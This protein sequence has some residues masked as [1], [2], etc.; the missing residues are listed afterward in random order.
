MPLEVSMPKSSGEQTSYS[1]FCTEPLL[2]SAQQSVK[3]CILRD[4]LETRILVLRSP[5]RR[6]LHQNGQ[7][8]GFAVEMTLGGTYGGSLAEDLL[9]VPLSL[10][11]R[12][13]RGFPHFHSDDGGGLLTATRP[14]PTKIGASYRFLHRTHFCKLA[15]NSK[16]HVLYRDG[17]GYLTADSPRHRSSNFSKHLEKKSTFEQSH[18]NGEQ[19]CSNSFWRP[20]LKGR[21]VFEACMTRCP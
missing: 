3:V 15:L 20:P 17:S 8:S 12:T 5:L 1:G 16:I 19:Y 2:G 6:H 4:F 7:N 11:T 18:D 9:P 21:E 14:S 10:E 13:K